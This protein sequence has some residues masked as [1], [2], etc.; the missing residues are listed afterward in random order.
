MSEE[1]TLDQLRNMAEQAGLKLPA[2]E[3]ERLLPGV[4]RSRQQASELRAL[5][6]DSVEPAATFSA[7][8]AV[9]NPQIS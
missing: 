1:I 9:K 4:N 5:A 8:A 6:S 7:G 2:E 3:L